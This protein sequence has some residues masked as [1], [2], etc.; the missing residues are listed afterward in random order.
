MISK[1]EQH[2]IDQYTRKMT[3]EWGLQTV[4]DGHITDTDQ[5]NQGFLI[6]ATEKGWVTKNPPHRLTAKGFEVAVSFLKR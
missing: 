2:F 3:V 5:R 1:A 4:V 6:G